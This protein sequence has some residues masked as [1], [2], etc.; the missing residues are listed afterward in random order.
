MKLPS[1]PVIFSIF[2]AC[3]AAVPSLA[4]ETAPADLSVRSVMLYSSGVGYFEH[5]GT[6]RD[7]TTASLFFKTGQINDVLK[8]LVME[9]ADGGRISAVVYPSQEPLAR[10][11]KSF[12]VDLSASP[13]LATLLGQL[14]GTG[15]RVWL[16]TE[17]L[18]GVILGLEQKPRM[19]V[20]KTT[21]EKNVPPG[22]AMNLVCGSSIRW[23]WLD[24][25]Q[26]LELA[27]AG[28]QEELNRALAAIAGA[29][30][31]DRKP[32]RINFEGQGQRK[33][34][35]GYV[36]ETPIWK[37]SYRLILD[38]AGKTASLQGWAI[39]ENQ[40]D[41]DW[42]DIQLSLI[43]G[44]PISFIQELYQPLYVPRPT[45]QQELAVGAGPQTYESGMES[46]KQVQAFARKGMELRSMAAP[47]PS[48]ADASAG[49]MVAE[50]PAQIPLDPTRGI[51]SSAATASLGEFFQYSIK[52]VSLPRRQSAMIP[53]VTDTIETIPL[54]IYNLQ[55]LPTHPLLGAR[56]KNTTGKH[57]AAGPITVLEG[58]GYIGDA[59][60]EGFPAGQQRLI[61]FGI[62]LQVDVLTQPTAQ[63]SAITFGRI[64]KGVLEITRKNILARDYTMDNKSAKNRTLVIEHAFQGGWKLVDSPKPV[65]TT[66]TLYRFEDTVAA[67]KASKLTVREELVTGQ[68]IAILPAGVDELAALLSS[69]GEIPRPVKEAMGQ[70]ITRK[71]ALEQTR[72]QINQR[73]QQIDQITSEQNRIRENMKTV[74]SDNAYYTRLLNK[75]NEQETQIEKLRQEQE[76]LRQTLNGQQNDLEQWLAEL[77]V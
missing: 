52:N 15:V 72:Q 51:I 61:S 21:P 54:S 28:L 46:P 73:Q 68:T 8:S 56:L 3:V 75:L 25:V 69:T 5:A 57:L 9:D 53:I 36:T 66:D 12:Q 32:V 40:T 23:V 2:L 42:T 33:V 31:Q 22:W 47:A 4:A 26:R 67:G 39:V 16:A 62:D 50:L 74:R 45:V 17:Q 6:V 19:G 41:N 48:A 29:R 58:G 60:L 10:Q 7:T 20:E 27:D 55:V 71:Q 13:S 30:N 59:R 77:N 37:C 1:L 76:S 65:E 34:R 18:E 35:L 38:E 43:S 14:R 24:E 11:L 49:N 64:N 44:R 63:T 70:I